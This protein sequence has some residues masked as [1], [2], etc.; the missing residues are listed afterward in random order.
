MFTFTD[1]R[2]NQILAGLDS[3]DYQRLLPFLKPVELAAGASLHESG[4]ALRDAW[5]PA[6]CIVAL[7]QRMNDGAAT[8]IATVG[9][10]GVVGISLFMG[11]LSTTTDALVRSPGTAYRIAGAVLKAAFADCPALKSRLLCYT[12]S[13]MAQMAQMAVCNRHH[14]LDQQLCRWLLCTLDRLSS[15]DMTVTQELIAA[16]LGVRR[17]GVT[18]AVGRLQGL[19]VIAYRRGHIKVL[20]RAGLECRVCEC[21]AVVRGESARPCAR[22]AQAGSP[23]LCVDLAPPVR[24]PSSRRSA[25]TGSGGSADSPMLGRLAVAR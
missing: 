24:G 11:D 16:M 17:E 12:Q 14:S 18:E 21:Y 2:Q 7:V 15:L 19:G 13:L 9:R 3:T 20:D 6:D 22:G 5:F 4:G 25:V 8:E 23:T 10:D 1:P